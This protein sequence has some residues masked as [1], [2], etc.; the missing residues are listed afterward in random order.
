MLKQNRH[1]QLIV[2]SGGEVY[3]RAQNGGGI[4]EALFER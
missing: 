3:A 4:A 2:I 1:Q